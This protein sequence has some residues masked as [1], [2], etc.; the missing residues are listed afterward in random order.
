ML[1]AVRI[2]VERYPDTGGR[3]LGELA[4]ME[5]SADFFERRLG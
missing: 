3:G 4:Y 2:F 1:A 5:R